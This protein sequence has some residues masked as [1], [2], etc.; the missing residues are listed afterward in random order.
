MGPAPILRVARPTDDLAA[1]LPFYEKG[2]GRS[3]FYRF[4]NP[5]GYRVILEHAAWNS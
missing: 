3:V 5:G 2:P 1:L 4:E